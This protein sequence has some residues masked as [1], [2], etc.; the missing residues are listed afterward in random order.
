MSSSRFW[1]SLPIPSAE[2]S[3]YLQQLFV[4]F[5]HNQQSIPKHIFLIWFGSDLPN[6]EERPYV[7]NL[8]KHKELN[9]DAIVE[10]IVAK[11]LLAQAGCLEKI[12]TVCHTNGI[13]LSDVHER[14]A[15]FINY[16]LIKQCLD[17]PRDYVIASDFLRL[18]LIYALRSPKFL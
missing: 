13:I 7:A 3:G 6:S 2:S 15:S 5:T 12:V 1:R 11:Q 10:L 18:A 14:C 8:L 17:K 9:P 16:D 4:P